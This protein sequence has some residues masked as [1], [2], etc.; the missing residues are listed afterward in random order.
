MADAP[1][2]A[3]IGCGSYVP[4]KVLTN[5]DLE[6]MV[7]TNDEWIVTRTGISERRVAAPEQAA[8]DLALPAA[9]EALE[10]AG[11]APADLDAIVV[12]TMTPDMNFPS[13]AAFLQGQLGELT[14]P[15]F[16]LSAACSGYVY[17]LAQAQG[18]IATGLAAH[19]LV[20]GAEALSKITDYE[21]RTSCILFGDGAGA[22]V[23]AAAEPGARGE[24][25]Y[26]TLGADGINNNSMTLPA[27]GSRQPATVESVQQKLHTIHLRGREVYNLAVRRIVEVVDECLAACGLSKDDHIRV[28]AHQMNLRIMQASAERLGT[29]MDQWYVNIDRYGNTGAA[30]IPIALAEARRE[31][32]I[33]PGMATVMVSFGAGLT[34]A[35]SVV[36]W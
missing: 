2:A 4:E 8:S 24:V 22:A 6:A 33:E 27:G 30:T 13:T 26:T 17:A 7:D 14:C 31:G 32:F 16:D 34:W 21:D 23:L 12:A 11:L 36:Q 9:Q 3:I 19:V 35:G 1:R 15:A 29:P 28:I 25:L 10:E 20:V 5:H 18:M